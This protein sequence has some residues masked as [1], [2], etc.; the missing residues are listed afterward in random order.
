MT[1]CSCSF[2]TCICCSQDRIL[3]CLRVLLTLYLSC[4]GHHFRFIWLT[5]GLRKTD[6]LH[7]LAILG[8]YLT[9]KRHSCIKILVILLWLGL[10]N[11]GYCL[12]HSALSSIKKVEDLSAIIHFTVSV[13]YKALNYCV[14]F[15]VECVMLAPI[16]SFLLTIRVKVLQLSFCSLPGHMVRAEKLLMDIKEHYSTILHTLPLFHVNICIH[17]HEYL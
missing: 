11:I 8:D 3:D 12:Q 1:C 16:Q 5:S 14:L 2:F 4:E 6:G 9:K 13:I 15:L 17:V 10:D 7:C